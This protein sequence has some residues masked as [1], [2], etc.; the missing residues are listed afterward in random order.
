MQNARYVVAWTRTVWTVRPTATAAHS[1]PPLGVLPAPPPQGGCGAGLPF[2]GHGWPSPASPW[3]VP[4]PRPFGGPPLAAPAGGGAVAPRSGGFPPH[5]LGGPFGL[6]GLLPLCSFLGCCPGRLG[7]LS[8]RTLYPRRRRAGRQRVRCAGLM[9][10]LFSHTPSAVGIGLCPARPLGR[11]LSWPGLGTWLKTA[12]WPPA[13]AG[14]GSST[15]LPK[16]VPSHLGWPYK[17]G[18]LEGRLCLNVFLPTWSAGA[19]AA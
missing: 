3:G 9:M 16:C 13:C 8:S 2:L 10:S 15:A 19:L 17:V 12:P 5:S 18:C 6:G 4:S 11:G 1:P 14:L 7:L